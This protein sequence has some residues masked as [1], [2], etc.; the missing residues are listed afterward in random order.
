MLG[1]RELPE[2][3]VTF[4]FTD[5]EGST[6]LLERYPRE[7]GRLIARH[8]ELLER[9]VEARGGVVFETI[10]DAVYAAFANPAEAVEAAAEAQLA[11]GREDW[12]PL[13]AITVRMGL[14]TGVV[15]RR[16]AHYFGPAL[17]R[18]A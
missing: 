11:L 6:R 5:V 2:G 7:Y 17:Y 1:R 9:A 3:D 13:D 15:E 8:H 12:T 16:G 4:L 18:C 10:G 14:H